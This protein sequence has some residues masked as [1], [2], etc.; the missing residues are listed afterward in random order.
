[1]VFEI[2]V[3]DF[4]DFIIICFVCADC[5]PEWA[6]SKTGAPMALHRAL[7]RRAE[8]SS[9]QCARAFWTE[10]V[11]SQLLFGWA[12]RDFTQK[13]IS[14]IFF[15]KKSDD[16]KIRN[17]MNVNHKNHL[18]LLERKKRDLQIIFYSFYDQKPRFAIFSN[19]MLGFITSTF[20]DLHG[21]D[22]V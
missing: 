8:I 9:A 11:R 4:W 13:S 6:E 5:W 22:Y 7:D 20:T 10:R 2:F 21:S 12:S 1:M 19:Q 17:I 15:K 3:W 16:V 18:Y 14:C